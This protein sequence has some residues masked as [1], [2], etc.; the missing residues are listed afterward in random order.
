MNIGKSIKIAL[1]QR[2]L[3]QVWL[4]NE[5]NTSSQ[6]I[7]NYVSKP[8]LNGTTIDKLAK[9]FN[10]PSSEFIALGEIEIEG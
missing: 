4:A 7:T 1:A 2:E 10:M 3:T 6:N 9:A 5:L 8:N